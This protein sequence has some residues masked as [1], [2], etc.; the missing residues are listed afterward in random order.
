M[1]IYS[2]PGPSVLAAPG[3]ALLVRPDHHPVLLPVRVPAPHLLRQPRIHVA[4]RRQV[5]RVADYLVQGLYYCFNIGLSTQFTCARLWGWTLVWSEAST[6]AMSRQMP[7][8]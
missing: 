4:V 6:A 1:Q 5:R 8:S 3:D 7:S 2:N